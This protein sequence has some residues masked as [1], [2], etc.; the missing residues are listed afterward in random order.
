MPTLRAAAFVFAAAIPHVSSCYVINRAFPTCPVVPEF[1]TRGRGLH[2]S[3]IRHVGPVFFLLLALMV[4]TE[5]QTNK[6]VRHIAQPAM[7]C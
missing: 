3:L 5:S 2:E 1:P 6:T 4:L 7:M